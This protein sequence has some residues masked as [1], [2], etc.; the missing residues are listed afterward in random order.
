VDAFVWGVIGSAAGIAGAVAAIVFGLIPLLRERKEGKEIPPVLGLADGGAEGVRS[1][2]APVVVGEIPQEPVAFQSRAGL[3]AGPENGALPG[4]IVVVRAVTG[5]RGVGKTHL[6]AEF[7][8]AR[9]ADRWRLVAWINSEDA[10]EML[11]GL[12]AVS[13]A[14]SLQAADMEASGRAVRH[15]LETGGQRCLLVFDNAC[16]PAALRPFIPAGGAAQVIITSNEHS[17]GSLGTG[18]PLDVFTEQEGLAFLAERTGSADTEGAR[19][20]AAELGYLPLALAQ[21]AAV[22]VGQRLEYGTYLGRL[23]ALSVGELLR[24]EEAGQYPRGVAAAVLLSLEAIRIGDDNESA[25]GVMELL[26]VLSAAG[27]RRSIIYA[28]GCRGVPGKD[29]KAADVA[30]R[31]LA[32]LAGASLLTFSVDGSTVAAHRLVMRVIR[33]EAAARDSLAGICIA[34]GGLL[35]ELAIS[36]EPYWYRDRAAVRD[37]VEQIMSLYSASAAC[38]DDTD[39]ARLLI[40]IRSRAAWFLNHLG[41][42]ASQ[43]IGVA[44]SLLADQER[45]LG[46]DHPDTMKTCSSLAAAYRDAG[47]AD[48]AIALDEETLADR[49]RMLGSD[50]PDTMATRNSL[51]ISLLDAG[52]MDEAIALHEQA[53]AER[54]RVLG[55]DHPDT[56]RTRDNLAIDY[57]AVGRTAEAIILHEH[58]LADFERVL[59]SDHPDT[60]KTR[61]NLALSYRSAGRTDEAIGLHEQTLADCERLLGSDHPDTMATR[62]NLAIAYRVAGRMAEAIALYEQTLAD[63]E[64]VIGSDHPDTLKTR[65]NLAV[66]YQIA[67]RRR[68]ILLRRKSNGLPRSQQDGRRIPDGTDLPG[69]SATATKPPRRVRT[70]VELTSDMPR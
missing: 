38:Q 11:A 7:A 37:L 21:A 12:A 49:E 34:A 65:H 50:H 68:L 29:G 48:D 59:G 44:Q 1:G 15:W 16:D 20:V 43:A 70:F 36:L 39:L 13:A 55:C 27:V 4:R 45:I 6:A 32:R 58:A 64:R 56:M 60:M 31:A 52:W 69:L 33:E 28:A 41:D 25:V 61:G 8:R 51:A 24:P 54:E 3:L 47:R 35:N 63:R 62:H 18:V 10:A 30:D 19:M 46:S 57:Q 14:L 66:T 42:S 53:L 26:A 5:M 23:S 17:M 40:Q 2:D 22:I 9:L 67:R